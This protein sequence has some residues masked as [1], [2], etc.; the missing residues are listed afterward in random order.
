MS[1]FGKIAG[2]VFNPAGAII[3]GVGKS[4]GMSDDVLSVGKIVHGFG[5]GNPLHIADGIDGLRDNFEGG[6]KFQFYGDYAG[7]NHGDLS[8]PRPKDPTQAAFYDHD[9]GYGDNGYFDPKTDLK[10]MKDL[11]L[12]QLDPSLPLS[13]RIHGAGAMF[14]F[15]HVSPVAWA[16]NAAKSLWDK[17]F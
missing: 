5:T 4:L 1:L 10:L 11:G 3:D 2:A 8:K 7:P 12:L 6:F 17:I 13:D 15:A 14:I 9:K 16:G